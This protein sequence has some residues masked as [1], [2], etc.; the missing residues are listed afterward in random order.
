MRFVRTVLPLAATALVV[1]GVAL[2][3]PSKTTVLPT[4]KIGVKATEYQFTM[5][6]TRVPKGKVVFTIA[7]VGTEVHDFKVVGKATKSRFITAGQRA[8]LTLS[9][10]KAGSYQY[11]CTIG[12]HAIKGMR[13]VLVVK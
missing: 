13:G 2:A 3:A 4:T 7:N 10:P 5:T 1:G 6:K 12:E 9:F 8:T 11:V